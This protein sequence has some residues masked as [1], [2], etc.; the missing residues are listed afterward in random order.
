MKE[1]PL[2]K[3]RLSISKKEETERNLGSSESTSSS[4]RSGISTKKS[5]QDSNKKSPKKTLK[6]KPKQTATRRSLSPLKTPTKRSL[7]PQKTP[8]KRSLS[9]LKISTKKS[10]IKKVGSP[11]KTATNLRYL[12]FSL[13]ACLAI[14]RLYQHAN[15]NKNDGNFKYFVKNENAGYK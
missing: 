12:S 8:T 15:T 3:P 5:L 11:G 6:E 2:K 4:Q 1:T 7:S 13:L 9:P 14:L 10:P